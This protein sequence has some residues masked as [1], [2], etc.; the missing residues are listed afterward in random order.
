[1]ATTAGMAF[2]GAHEI[3]SDSHPM[4]IS[5]QDGKSFKYSPGKVQIY[6]YSMDWSKGKFTGKPH[7]YWENLWFPVDFPLNQSIEI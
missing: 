5:H 3:S 7:I 6:K 2:F 1:V 4:F